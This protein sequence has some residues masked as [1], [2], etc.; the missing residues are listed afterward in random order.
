MIPNI[1]EDQVHQLTGLG[2]TLFP[3]RYAIHPEETWKEA[4]ARWARGGAAAEH[5]ENINKWEARFYTETVT[6]RFI[7][8][9]RIMR[10]LGRPLQA[11]GN[12]FCIGPS[13]FDSREGWGQATKE[14]II[15]SGEGGG[16]GLNGSDI[17][18][19]GTPVGRTGGV[20]TG[21]VSF[22]E[23]LNAAAGVIRGG[24]GRRAALMVCLNHDHPDLEEFLSKKLDLEELKNANASVGFMN[25]SIED[26]VTKVQNNQDHELVWQDSVIKT[27]KAKDIWDT[28]I[29]NSVKAAEPGILNLYLMNEMNNLWY[30]KKIVASN[31][32]GEIGLEPYGMCNLGCLV[33]PRFVNRNST[34]LQW[35]KLNTTITTAIRFLDNMINVGHYPFEKIKDEMN[36]TRR[37]G[38]GVTGLHTMLL[39]LGMK[40]DSEEAF[41]FVA[42]MMKFI[43][44]KAY[45]ASIFLAVEKGQFPLLDRE[46]FTKSG[47]CKTLK[48]SLRDKILEYGI[49]NCA[50][51]TVP[52]H[53]TGSIICNV[54]PGL[55]VMFSPAC[56][57]T[58][59][60]GEETKTII[61]FD[62]MAEKL[63]AENGDS[64]ILQGALD[65]SPENHMKMQALVQ[66]HVDNAISKTI[67]LPKG[68]S[69]EQELSNLFMKY[70]P[71][72]KGVT[73]YTAGSRPN[74]P[75]TPIP[76][77]EALKMGCRGGA[78]DI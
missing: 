2:E 54:T 33:L 4:C 59:Q 5:G 22:F 62:P 23:I 65:V 75:L 36:N 17:R 13:N 34:D 37:L 26:F 24:G 35:G 21:A 70:L 56:S 74:E 6:N 30:C 58:Y 12:C 44:H 14:V 25:E 16:V 3:D 41:A 64:S 11:T 38:L 15:I 40:Y 39:Q 28:I 43:K 31:P 61:V 20:A 53:G 72:L 45:E 1:P 66:E 18:P 46:Q 55:E 47:F 8:G 27:V 63:L 69:D 68:Y 78:C 32:C 48:P 50:V 19:R 76:F 49:R 60:D 52:P 42:K 73:L 9:G 67:W 7:P 57:R 77:E 51:L 10:S 71:K 29:H